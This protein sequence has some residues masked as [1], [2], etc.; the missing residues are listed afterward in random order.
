MKFLKRMAPL[1]VLPIIAVTVSIAQAEDIVDQKQCYSLVKDAEEAISEN[2]VLGDKSE[3][4]LIEVMALAKQRCEE[5][6]FSN[7]KDLLELAR[8][9]VASE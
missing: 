5:K 6:Q 2:P 7:A 1:L 3:K 4:I 9:L 8:G